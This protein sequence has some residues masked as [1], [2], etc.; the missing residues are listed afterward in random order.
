MD[1]LYTNF[2]L[3]KPVYSSCTSIFYNNNILSVAEMVVHIWY[4]SCKYMYMYLRVK[5]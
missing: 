3:Y 4:M 2:M 5:K 1:L